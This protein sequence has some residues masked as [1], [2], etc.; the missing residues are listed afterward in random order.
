MKKTLFFSI[1]MAVG[2]VAAAQNYEDILRFS[3]TNATGTARATAMGGAFGALGG[4]LSSIS[5]NP[6]GIGVFRK[7]EFSVTPLLNF[8]NTDADGGTADKTSFQLGT[9]GIVAT[10][11]GGESDWKSFNFGFNYTQLNNFNRKADMAIQNS[12]TSQLDAYAIEADNTKPDLLDPFTLRQAYDTYLIN[13]DDDLYY[14]SALGEGEMINQ[15]KLLKEKGYQGEYAFSFGANYKDKLYMGLTLGLQATY[16]RCRSQYT[17]LGEQDAPSGFDSYD[18]Y[19]EMRITGFGSN[20]K[21]G[22]IYRPIPQLRIGA[23]IHT[24]TWYPDM[25]YRRETFYDAYY[26]TDTDPNTGRED[27]ESHSQGC[28]DKYNFSMRTPWRAVLSLATVMG[29]KAI[30]S[31][32]YEYVDYG[33]AKYTD[34]PTGGFFRET[35]RAIK[36]VYTSGH[37]FRL[38]AEYRLN[39]LLS[40]RAGYNYL[41]TPFKDKG[42]NLTNTIPGHEKTQT[43]S[44]GIGLNFGSF[45]C[46]AAY[47][48]RFSKDKSVFYY[49]SAVIDDNIHEVM[50]EP[51]SN[52][53]TEHQARVT[54][55]VK[56]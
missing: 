53:Y 19:E 56:F 3:M 8:N 18:F 17:E 33:S 1:I 4:D 51:I 9:I 43:I 49:A 14:H 10:I 27:G 22:V 6:A 13:P 26:W 23:A 54:L 52:D 34:G 47:S 36:E 31:A 11:S 55:G 32:D 30:L 21:L 2:M 35:N 45:Y 15:Y 50:A 44:G 25:D 46:D 12:S 7:S 42:F 16:F 41:A 20:V 24:P 28:F 29:Q 39:S 5:I 40:L 37:N 48:Y 38:G